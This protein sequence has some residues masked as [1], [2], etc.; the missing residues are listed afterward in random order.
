MTAAQWAIASTAVLA[1]FVVGFMLMLAGY[2]IGRNRRTAFAEVRRA[3][4]IAAV[5]EMAYRGG[6]PQDMLK[7]W[8]ND[9]VF[10]EVIVE[11]LNFLHGSHRQRVLKIATEIGI[12]DVLHRRLSSR[13]KEVR[14][15]AATGLS[16]LADED[17][18]PYLLE[19]LR[20][21]VGGVQINAAHALARIGKS[22]TLPPV[23]ALMAAENGWVRSRVADALVSFGSTA[24][25][26]ITLMLNEREARPK[27]QSLLIQVL[28]QIGDSTAEPVLLAGLKSGN[29]DIRVR[30]TAALAT[31]GSPSCVPA[32]AQALCDSDWRVR[33]QA[34]N[35]LKQR[36][37][38]LAIPSLMIA[39]GDEAWRVRQNAAAALA[40]I[41]GGKRALSS[42]LDD[43][44]Q[45]ARDVA[46]EHLMR[47]EPLIPD[48][49]EEIERERQVVGSRTVPRTRSAS[50][51]SG[52]KHAAP[53]TGHYVP[54]HRAPRQRDLSKGRHR[55]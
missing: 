15:A 51:N 18:I 35:S 13:R 25:A 8:V 31:T 43:P 45:F 12:N 7:A 39:L 23:L 22:E 47:S 3:A 19:A 48:S 55:P 11:F 30:S 37:D 46:T 41:P 2:K 6:Y 52:P 27:T 33:A 36:M 14:A 5:G 10:R 20:D 21:K 24:V 1:S 4:Y 40:A 28:G 26:P 50:R 44:D 54:Q 9:R 42:A 17:S 29:T 53:K 38:P 34:A 32:L 16:Q 49:P